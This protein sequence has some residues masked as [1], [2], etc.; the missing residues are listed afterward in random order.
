MRKV[1]RK[2]MKSLLL[3]IILVNR[4]QAAKASPIK[5]QSARAKDHPSSLLV[6]IFASLF[7]VGS[8]LR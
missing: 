2:G 7:C 3:E 4:T 8:M 5:I 1:A 6:S